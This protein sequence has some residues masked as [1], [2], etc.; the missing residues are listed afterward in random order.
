MA[1]HLTQE[2]RYYIC[3]QIASFASQ[4]TIAKKLGV[5]KSTISKEIKRNSRSVGDYDSDYAGKKATLVRSKASRAKAFNNITVKMKQ[6]I[7]DKLKL[8]WSPEQISGRMKIDIG[9]K[10]CHETIYSYIRHDRANKG[11]LYKLLAHRGKRYRNSSVSSTSQIIGRVDISK[12]P[13]IVDQKTR[14]GDFEI[15]TIVSARN[16]GKSCLFTMV[17]R[18]SKMTFIRKTLDKSA[19]QIESAIEDIYLKSIVPIITLT[20]DN[21]T[22]FANHISIS[23]SLGCSFYF[24]RPYHSCDRALNEN[25][26]GL[27]RRY[28]PKGTNFD[29]ISESQIVCIQDDL[30]NRPRKTLKYRTPNE[31]M[32]KYLQRVECNRIK[33]LKSTVS[34]D[35]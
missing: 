3:L 14:I 19:L 4:S 20:S 23:E 35:H 31:V 28:L 15:D 18:R 5:S 6:Y 34:F 22:E 7:C 1:K 25:T 12:R 2:Q 32:S 27:I 8:S 21:G 10:I 17:D 13:K 11:N 29:T 26:N 30:N 9:K 24:A 16:T 33:N